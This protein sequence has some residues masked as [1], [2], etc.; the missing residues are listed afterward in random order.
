MAAASDEFAATV[1]RAMQ[2]PA[3]FAAETV[4]AERELFDRLDRHSQ[5]RAHDIVAGRIGQ[6]RPDEARSVSSWGSNSASVALLPR[7]AP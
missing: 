1:K 3:R 5:Q 6:E 4:L 2:D 7:L